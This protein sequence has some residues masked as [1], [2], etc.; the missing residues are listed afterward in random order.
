MLSFPEKG[1]KSIKPKDIENRWLCHLFL[2]DRSEKESIIKNMDTNVIS[3]LH[4][5]WYRLTSKIFEKSY[6]KK[7]FQRLKR[8]DFS[9]ICSNCVA[10]LFYH[11]YNLPF[12]SPT[13]NTDFNGEGFLVFANDL[14]VYLNKPILDEHLTKDGFIA[15]TLSEYEIIFPHSK[16]FEE[17]THEWN[18]R[19]E[20]INFNNVIVMWNA[21]E[22]IVDSKL[23]C[24]FDKLPYRKMMFTIDESLKNHPNTIFMKEFKTFSSMPLL[25]Y[26]TNYKGQRLYEYYFDWISFINGDSFESCLKNQ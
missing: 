5:N 4:Q 15:G 9:L 11:S 23:V 26:R 17:A 7:E 8:S 25:T 22:K 6:R 20:R 3:K 10:G 13:I 16:T 2:Y 19:K 12:L 24:L 21:K 14:E 18:R 1:R